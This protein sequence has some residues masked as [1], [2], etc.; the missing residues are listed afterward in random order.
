M[1]RCITAAAALDD[2]DLGP[3]MTDLLREG[4]VDDSTVVVLYIMLQR[5]GLCSL[6][7]HHLDPRNTM[8]D[9]KM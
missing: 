1:E 3:W 2:P 9:M 8:I 7:S 5:Y 4:A 6:L